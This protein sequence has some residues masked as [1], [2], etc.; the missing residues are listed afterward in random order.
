MKQENVLRFIPL[1]TQ[2]HRC[3]IIKHSLIDDS[4]KLIKFHICFV[5][6]SSRYH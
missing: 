3:D 4:K 5:G 1:T 2:T 6:D